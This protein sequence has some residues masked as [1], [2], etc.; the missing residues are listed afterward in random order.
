MPRHKA[1]SEILLYA[2]MVAP[3]VMRLKDGALLTGFRLAGPD[4]ES[5][6]PELWAAISNALN[7]ALC[8][9]DHGWTAHFETVRIPSNRGG[10]GE[11]LDPTCRLIDE[12]QAKTEFFSTEQWLFLTQA[13]GWTNKHSTLKRIKGWLYEEP[14]V[15]IA[16]EVGR[17]TERFEA[18]VHRV[19]N[20]LCTHLRI[21]R[22][23]SEPDNDELLQAVYYCLS[24][25]WQ[26]T[27]LP[28]VPACLDVLL[29]ED[30]VQGNPMVLGRR[31]VRA[32]SLRGYPSDTFAG[33]LDALQRLPFQVRWSH[34]FII[35]DYQQSEALL[36]KEQRRWQ[37]KS[38]SFAS[39]IMR[40]EGRLDHH[41]VERANELDAALGDLNAGAVLYGH[42]TSVLV[43]SGQSHEEIE[44]R[45]SLV[46][47]VAQRAGYIAHAET[48]NGLEAFIGSLPG[49]S[50][51]NVRK[52]IIHSLN[53]ADLVPISR[54]W[55]GEPRCPSPFFEKR[56]PALAEA[57]S[58]SGARFHLNLHVGDVG[59][60]LMLGPTGAGKST[61]LAYLASQFLRY[62]SQGAQVFAFDKGR[63]L[64]PLCAAIGDA[65]HV[66]FGTQAPEL[67]PLQDLGSPK[68]RAWA[69]EWIEQLLSLQAL[70]VDSSK[71]PQLIEALQTFSATSGGGSLTD[72][73]TTL[74]DASMR[75]ALGYYASEGPGGS[76]LDGERTDLPT[77]QFTVFEIE[78]LMNMGPKIVDATLLYLFRYIENKLDGRPT[79][80]LLDEA[81]LAL[82]NA[83]FSEKIREWLKVLRKNNCA[84]VMA[85]QSLSD[86]VNS[87]IRDAVLESCPTRLLLPN[88]EADSAM[89][90]QLYR[91]YLRLDDAQVA[92][93]AGAEKKRQYYYA[94]PTGTRLFE[95][96]LG[97]VA[98]SFLGASSK[99]DLRTIGALRA[100]HQERWPAQWLEQRG[101]PEAAAR[102]RTV[103]GH[104]QERQGEQDDEDKTLPHPTLE[105]A[106][107]RAQGHDGDRRALTHAG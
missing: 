24:G 18:T 43:I 84:V 92:L 57:R 10:R 107:G 14:K 29:A 1:S 81:W 55:S 7:D 90:R 80:L 32:V 26:K 56:S 67:C 79:L 89:M 22:F 5:S 46:G 37:Q 69:A 23:V 35:Q 60:T 106:F 52:P 95:L 85:T 100:A 88:P 61:L 70:R 44:A 86:V 12:E 15:S 104:P 39:Q 105:H 34:R 8:G 83:L 48:Y 30:W 19:F 51:Q 31:L 66:D 82:S 68:E 2:E 36:R 6:P 73:V 13:S 71:R 77:S 102:W 94:S 21:R 17:Q 72:F 97:P 38:R 99:P 74:Q 96:G 42:H 76:I 45:C 91:D 87:P 41:A 93:I 25:H 27:R 3:S 50:R 59:H 16:E 28:D 9:L 65:A 103:S 33:C 58:S 62:E 78:D 49:H 40:T 75:T 20:S 53:F 64:L 47:R 98:L 63:S 4:L 11:F 54:E 101:L